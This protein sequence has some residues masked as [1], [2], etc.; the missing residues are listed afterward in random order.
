[1][2]ARRRVCFVTGS[3]AEYG[4]IYWVLRE[5][6]RNPNVD[7]QIIVTGMHLSPEFGLTFRQIEQDGFVVSTKV[8]ML[9]SSDTAVG[10][11]KSIGLGVIGF[12]DA[13]DRL[14]PDL[15]VL[16][17]DRFELLAA[18]QAALIANVPIAHLCGGD[19]TEGAYD[20]A[21]RHSLTKMAHVHFPTNAVA[22]QRIRQMGEDP[23]CIFNFGSTQL[24][25]V[26][27]TKLLSLAELQ[28]S[29][30][31]QFLQRNLLVTFHPATLDSRSAADQ[32]AEVLAAL[33]SLDKN[34]G[35]IFTLPNADNDGRIIAE[36]IKTFVDKM[37]ARAVAYSSLGSVRY[38]STLAIV[39]AVVG[40]SSSGLIEAPS[41]HKPT[42]NIGDRQHG[43]V[44]PPSV[45]DCDAERGAVTAAIVRALGYDCS[46]ISNPYGDGR[47]ASHVAQKLSEVSL[48]GILQK[49]F[50]SIAVES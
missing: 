37:G 18:A 27:R 45:I 42:V 13:I 34:I 29:L 25:H 10:I 46:A 35:F 4:I 49:R 23:A 20:E 26:H 7:L 8:E 17:G 33:E 43:R 22:A 50:H 11:T 30:G 48:D 19:T 15:I 38:L 2:N 6:E 24:D 31:F 44:R 39:D 36:M 21:I 9:L 12:A 16:A 32:C 40:N 14:S 3:R 41:F 1:M 5:L 28:D 47:S